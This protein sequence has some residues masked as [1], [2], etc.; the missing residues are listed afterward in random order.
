MKE[1][2]RIVVSGLVALMMLL[3]LGFV[4]HRSLRFA[5]SLTGGII[6]IAAAVFMLVPLAYSGVKRI[7]SVRAAVKPRASMRTLLAWHIY[8][9]IIGPILA[10]IHT[11]HR[12][13]S[14][15]GVVLTTFMLTVVLSG[16]VGR[17]LMSQFSREIREKKDML[18][19]METAYAGMAAQLRT[20][21]ASPRVGL[22]ERIFAGFFS[23]DA[24]PQPTGMA[25]RLEA[26]RLAESMADLEYAVKTHALFKLWFA[27][28]LK[29]HIA[30]SAVFYVLMGVHIGSEIY[31]GL[32]WLN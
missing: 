11:G 1:R 2:E 32:R 23:V 6:G 10:L 19:Q 15:L 13:D 17:Y 21:T 16:F 27:R 20:S 3:W 28:W 30:I 5:G 14:P 9:G 4:L 29:F 8:A 31:Y 24:T 7:R 12:F 26:V 22:A 18:A 25:A